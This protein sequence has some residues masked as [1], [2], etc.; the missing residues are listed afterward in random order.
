ML[1]QQDWV[2]S[3]FSNVV[4]GPLFH[5]CDFPW[6][7]CICLLA[8][9]PTCI[10]NCFAAKVKA[11]ALLPSFTSAPDGLFCYCIITLVDDG[12]RLRQH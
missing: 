5:I 7:S 8:R 4:P 1:Y 9:D 12:T 2:S 10:P 11:H 3:A 6:Q